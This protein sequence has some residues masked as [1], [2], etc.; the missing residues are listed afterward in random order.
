MNETNGST[1]FSVQ[2]A[3]MLAEDIAGRCEDAHPYHNGW[4]ARCPNHQGKSDTSLSIDPADD[5]V[6]V[7]CFGG[8]A[9]T[10]VVH[11]MG[12][13][14]A[15][16][17]LRPSTNGHK[18][19][20]KVY[21]Y[22]DAQGT[23]VHQTVRYDS[24]ADRFRQRRPNPVNPAEYIWNLKGI[25]PVLYALPQVL[26]AV[27]RG[28]LIYIV[29]GEKDAD[30]VQAL[31]LTATTAPMG[32]GKWRKNYTEVLRGAHV[33]I[34]PDH[35]EPGQKHALRIAKALDGVAATL[36]IV[37]GINTKVPGSDVSDW[38]AA[39]GTRAALEAA[40]E[41]M[42]WY[43][44]PTDTANSGQTKGEA[45]QLD[46][47]IY[48]PTQP[49][50]R[51]PDALPYSDYTNAVA[52]VRDHGQNLRYCYPWKSW[53]VWTGTHWHRDTS[54][55]VMRLAKQTIKRL[56]RR[57]EHLDDEKK[58]AALMGHIKSSLSTA[59]LKA[60]L[61][62][63][64]SEPGIA[65]QPDELD[66]D[67]WL[68]NVANG[69]LDLRTGELR[70]HAQNDLLTKCLGIAYDSEMGCPQWLQF[71]EKAMQGNPELIAFIQKALGYSLTGSTREQCFF[72]LHGP[73]KT[74]K[75][76]FATIAKALLGPYGTQAEM[77]TFL[78]KDRETVRN[79]LADLAGMRLVSAIETD[80]GKRLAEA[81]IKQLTGGTDTIKAR[82]LFKEYFE[83]RPQFKIFLATNH[84]P[85]V[86]AADDA[87]WERIR[88]I[89]F[90]AQ[91]PKDQ[92]DKE[93]EGKLRAELPGIL[94]WAV[95]GC[96]QWQKD[97]GLGEPT[98][99]VEATQSYRDEMDDVG[100]FLA[101]CMPGEGYKTQATV[102]FKAYQQWGGRQCETQKGFSQ[103]LA[104]RG[105]EAKHLKTGNFWLGIG[106]F[107][108]ESDETDR[109]N[110]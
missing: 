21:D 12:L 24:A 64:Q 52:F 57:V 75:S 56:A 26:T 89:P 55:H 9:Q 67:I 45:T 51:N 95:R 100:Q 78:H 66:Q 86:N 10:A 22:Y 16:L 46:E 11:A 79:D 61:E 14:M 107:A 84:K 25:E 19:I 27:Q 106:L 29:E 36:K 3:E 17:F 34:L 108:P 15:D 41:N 7:K 103:A 87:V 31:G 90:S 65:V 35:D 42:S 2:T 81:L 80:E 23:L 37:S 68:L 5:R 69:T 98:A 58:I 93:L 63:A 50:P 91:I 94:A 28:E 1:A 18:C 48:G 109:I 38:L 104:D 101:T 49:K 105:Y 53:L 88:L 73:T 82:F 102:L 47:T 20:V 13:R 85:K 99:V 110:R 72:L 83:Y 33:R 76:T 4:R 74:G 8:C 6:I 77:S 59:K 44:V 96:Q 62:S 43:A 71:L 97:D 40:V 39:G 54:G 30:N 32:A 92:R 70:P 60:M